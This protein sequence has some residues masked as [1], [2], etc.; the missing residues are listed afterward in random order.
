[1]AYNKLYIDL[2]INWIPLIGIL[3]FV[4]LYLY[5][6]SLY[7]GGSQANINSE[8][9]DWI[10]N[11]WCNLMNEEGMNGQSNPARPY[12][13]F[14]MITLCMSLLVFFI[15][16]AEFY[17]GEKIWKK[18]IKISGICSMTCAI[19][20]FTE[21]HDLM[22][23]VSSFFGLFLVVGIIREIYRDELL[24]FKI[25]GILCLILLGLNNYIYYSTQFIKWLPLIQKITFLIVLIW[26][27]GLNFEVRK[28]I[29]PE[30]ITT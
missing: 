21:Y 3:L 30:K 20:M 22:T 27:L 4:L 11:Y 15:Q 6:S 10:N 9:Y 7:P 28:K 25:T 1:M 2:V 14:A 17:S 29:S 23:I 18:V 16:F 13:V 5:A 24:S 8:G 19:L 12:A 26:I